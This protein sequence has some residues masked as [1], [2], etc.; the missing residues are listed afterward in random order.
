MREVHFR[1]ETKILKATIE[2][3]DSSKNYYVYLIKNDTLSAVFY[4]PKICTEKNLRSNIIL[5]KQYSLQV[6]INAS[7]TYEYLT[8]SQSLFPIED[9]YFDYEEKVLFIEDCL[10]ICGKTIK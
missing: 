1:D 3:I 6:K 5:G 7:E 10:N 8:R 9:E 2:K 4:K